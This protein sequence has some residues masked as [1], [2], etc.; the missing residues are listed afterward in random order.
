MRRFCLT[1][2]L[3]FIF[4]SSSWAHAIDITAEKLQ[5]LNFS[6]EHLQRALLESPGLIKKQDENGWTILH[7]AARLGL[8]MDS[9]SAREVLDIL[10]ASSEIDLSIRDK[11]NNTPV[12]VAALYCKYRT[13]CCYIFPRFIRIAEEKG[14]DFSSLGRDGKTVLQIATIISY[15]DHRRLFA[16]VN[17][18]LTV[19]EIAKNPA[20]NTLST[21]GATAFF[22]A[23]NHGH[24]R[25]ANALLKA[26]SNAILYGSKDR[27]P[28]PMINNLIIK[29]TAELNSHEDKELSHYLWEFKNELE[30]IQR[31]IS[32]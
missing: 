29:I 25:E 4:F 11:D 26:G 7:H 31:K 14:F 24:I 21:T 8:I 18:V 17:N 30:K 2:I 28:L 12:H 6:A 15:S 1:A 3:N 5:A 23:I 22:Y 32:A 9:T 16:R 13:T 10:F 27:D 20:L 19:L